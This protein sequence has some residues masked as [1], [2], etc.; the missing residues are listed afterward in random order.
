M[1]I[2]HSRLPWLKVYS[3]HKDRS[4][5]NVGYA[6]PDNHPVVYVSWNDAMAF[7]TWLSAKERKYYLR[8]KSVLRIAIGTCPAT[9]TWAP[10]FAWR[11]RIEVLPNGNLA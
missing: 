10:A 6:Q 9:G 2:E 8:I 4:W 3:W 11:G 1:D 5:H 7:C